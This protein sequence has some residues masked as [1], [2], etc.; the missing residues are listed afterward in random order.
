MNDDEFDAIAPRGFKRKKR[1]IE[2]MGGGDIFTAAK[3]AEI[4]G[5]NERTIYRDIAE[6][7]KHGISISGAAGVGYQMRKQNGG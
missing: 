2:I 1:L 6:M 3:L 5:C 4:T 7:R